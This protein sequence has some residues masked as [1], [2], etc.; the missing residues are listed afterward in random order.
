MGA[1]NEDRA[2]SSSPDAAGNIFTTGY[3]RET[4]DFDPGAGI[5]TLT[6]AG[7]SD[8]FISKLDA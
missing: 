1:T 2:L 5:T 8:I 6:S 3:Y 4:S 7:F